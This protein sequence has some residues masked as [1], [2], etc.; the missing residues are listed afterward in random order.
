MGKGCG[1]TRGSGFSEGV[2]GGVPGPGVFPWDLIS[3]DLG[4]QS[5]VPPP[6]R[7]VGVFA[8]LGGGWGVLSPQLQISSHTKTLTME[9][10]GWC[11]LGEG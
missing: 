8:P 7:F 1:V 9:P 4:R 10:Q 11:L 6:H 5:R 2:S 3:T